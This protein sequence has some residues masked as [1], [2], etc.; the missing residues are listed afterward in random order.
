MRK[1]WTGNTPLP[2]PTERLSQ[3]PQLWK[4]TA[5]IAVLITAAAFLMLASSGNAQTPAANGATASTTQSGTDQSVTNQ[6]APP[7]PD[8]GEQQA[9]A[10]PVQDAGSPARTDIRVVRLSDVEGSVQIMRG[11]HT[12]FSQAVMNMP[13]LQGSRIVTGADGRAEIE[14]EDGSV[15]RITP[16]SSL[17]LKQLQVAP[18]DTLN[19]RVEQDTGLIY[20]ELR[21]D[22]GSRYTVM[23]GDRAVMPTVNS[24]FRVNLGATPPEVAVLDGSVQVEGAAHSY[25]AD[26]KQ[27]QTI[28]FGSSNGQQYK[29]AEG[30]MP[31][32]FDEWNDQRDQE[33]AQQAQN[34]TPAR[35]QQGGGSILDS[36]YGWSDLDNAGGW[37]PL[38]GYGTVWQP[39]GVGP[40]FNPYG[41]GMWANYGGLGYTWISGYSWGWLPFNCGLWS[42]ID[43][44]GWGWM[45][46]PYGC[47]GFGIGFGYYGG[48]GRYG[49]RW[50]GRYSHTNI[51]HAPAGYRVPVPPSLA[52]GQ[53]APSL[54]RVGS[55][56]A[57]G[58]GVHGSSLHGSRSVNLT[59][60]TLR[61][62]GTKI[63]P[64]HSMMTGVHV[65]VRNAALFNNYPA[66]TFPG[67]IRNAVLN[68]GS[69][70]GHGG[71]VTTKGAGRAPARLGNLQGRP[72]GM[73]RGFV[74]HGSVAHGSMSGNHATAFSVP[75]G[76]PFAESAAFGGDHAAFGQ[77]A[78]F[79]P[80]GA[81]GGAHSAFSSGG[82][83]R[84]GFGSSGGFHG[85]TGGFHG[86]GG[87]SSGGHG[88]GFGG[89]GFSGGGGHGGGGG[90]GGHAH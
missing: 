49:R 53:T 13:L 45:P 82:S 38:P 27:G 12:Q 44:F 66:H 37:Y 56:A 33:A 88:G 47:G 22:P 63:A 59:A 68:S 5:G 85:S 30:I 9:S 87:F 42:D 18:G 31:N 25:Q 60:R 79:G 50:H 2:S 4:R 10:P 78:S 69:S 80:R 48:Y 76:E 40:G 3:S 36:G 46:G 24:T 90:G 74:A 52:R 29:V 19:T 86:G 6:P 71:L 89:G 65:P 23:V 15:A 75:H 1:F 11:E 54:V 16:N 84:G 58:A 72:T 64:L 62:N 34:Q 35:V 21:S 28:Q 26:V 8:Q 67:G 57:S 77:H 32:G 20:Y 70:V 43:G 61:F 17:S 83:F 51:A 41:Y 55:P 14:F 39:Y 81:F 7:P 73:S